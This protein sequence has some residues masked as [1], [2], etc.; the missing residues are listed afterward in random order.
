MFS[1][2]R[3]VKNMFLPYN[4]LTC[5][6]VKALKMLTKQQKDRFHEDASSS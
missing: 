1:Q 5:A 2:I 3:P 6:L 4:L